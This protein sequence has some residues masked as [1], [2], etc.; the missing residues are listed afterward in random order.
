MVLFTFSTVK[1]ERTMELLELA[2]MGRLFDDIRHILVAR[3][4]S[5]ASRASL[6][7]ESGRSEMGSARM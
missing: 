1:R 5:R 3:A 4:A 2:R 7:S 6:A